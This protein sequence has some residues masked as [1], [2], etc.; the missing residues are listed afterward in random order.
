MGRS[1]L[2]AIELVGVAAS[3]KTTLLRALAGRSNR[4]VDGLAF[5][6][7]LHVRLG[8]GHALRLLPAWLGSRDRWLTEKELRS[9]NYV[10][11]WRLAVERRQPGDGVVVFDH[12]P[13]FRLARLRAHGPRVVASRSFQRWSGRAVRAWA[14]LLDAVVWLDAPDELLVARIDGRAEPHRMQGGPAQDTRRF[15]ASYREVYAA[16]LRELEAAG[17]PHPLRIDTSREAP[18]AIAEHLIESFGL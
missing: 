18:G 12:G 10:A 11:G 2:R 13:L 5:P 14:P 16:L 17:G 4:V 8:V 1:P 7:H 9:M 3:G 6:T 15:L